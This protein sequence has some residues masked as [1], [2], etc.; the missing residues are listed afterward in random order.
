[1]VLGL[2]LC[3]CVCC[4]CLIGFV[5]CCC[6]LCLLC[7]VSVYLV[8]LSFVMLFVVCL[9]VIVFVVDCVCR[10]L[11]V[12]R[13]LHTS[14]FCFTFVPHILLY[15][16]VRII[17]LWNMLCVRCSYVVLFVL[18][19][20]LCVSFVDADIEAPCF[21]CVCVLMHV[22]VML[23]LFMFCVLCF[24]CVVECVQMIFVCARCFVGVL[25]MIMSCVF[26]C[27]VPCVVVGCLFVCSVFVL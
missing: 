27:V 7:G 9:F 16:C 18:L 10:C 2:L 24:V 23:S 11:C 5:F 17:V 15:C 6:L 3:C 20:L 12:V 1:M 25:C 21:G 4:V 8:R 13:T 22:F 26:V 14:V 19:M